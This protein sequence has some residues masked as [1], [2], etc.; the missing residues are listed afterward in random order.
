MSHAPFTPEFT[1]FYPR[2]SS[3]EKHPQNPQSVNQA[4]NYEHIRSI[5]IPL[6]IFH[7]PLFISADEFSVA[8]IATGT[9]VTKVLYKCRQ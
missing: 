9:I 5:I 3:F 2:T 6:I 4:R 1:P 8:T 7:D